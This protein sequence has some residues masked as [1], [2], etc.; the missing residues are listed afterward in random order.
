YLALLCAIG[1]LRISE[2]VVSRRH[3]EQA[4]ARGG[5]ELGRELML[6]M[7]LLHASFL[8]SCGI[9]VVALHRPFRP[10]LGTTML[11]VLVAAQALR[12]WCQRSL[13]PYWNTRV[14][15]VPGM[16]RVQRGPYRWLRHPNYLAVTAEM[17]ALP[18]L[19]G[20]WITAAVY[21]VANALLLRA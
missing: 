13:G 1:L 4:F 16:P 12:L 10:A 19:H 9:E 11:L 7:K 5:F 21:S 17:F 18:L 2:L 3:A 14:I 8:L 20:A 15:I 6:P